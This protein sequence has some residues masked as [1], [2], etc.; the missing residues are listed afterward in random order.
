MPMINQPDMQSQDPRSGKLVLPPPPPEQ[1]RM[2]NGG[3]QGH[4]RPEHFIRPR[5]GLAPKSTLARLA[6][7]WQKDPAYKVLMVANVVGLL[8]GIGFGL[9][10]FAPFLGDPNY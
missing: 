10:A 7:Y 4:L 5:T 6:Y 3:Q 2:Y 8:A 1:Q 9:L